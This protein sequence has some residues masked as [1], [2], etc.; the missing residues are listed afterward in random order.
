MA[1]ATYSNDDAVEVR[2]LRAYRDLYLRKSVRGKALIWFYYNVAPYMAYFVDKI[3][4]LKR[5]SR[6]CLDL[7]VAHIERRTVLKREDY[8]DKNSSRN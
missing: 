7:I 5:I 1:T 8:I 3:S 2:F 6:C 4:P